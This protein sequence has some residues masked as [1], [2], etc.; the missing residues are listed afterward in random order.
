M[1]QLGIYFVDVL[2]PWGVVGSG[3]MTVAQSITPGVKFSTPPPSCRGD[4]HALLPFTVTGGMPTLYTLDFSDEALAVGF[5]N[6]IDGAISSNQIYIDLPSNV[7]TG[8]YKV[9]VSLTNGNGCESG[10]YD[11]SFSVGEDMV[12][13][14]WDDVLICN[15]QNNEFVSY[16]WYKNGE[17]ITGAQ[18]QYY[19]ELGGFSGDY[20]VVAYRN[21]HSSV[22]SCV[23]S[24]DNK[25]SVAISPN[26]LKRHQT[27]RVVLPFSTDVLFGS[28]LEIVDA[29]GRTLYTND[30][31]EA[32]NG[33]V[34]DYPAGV[35]MVRISMQSGEVITEK[36]VVQ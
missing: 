33:I 13:E 16:Q 23:K 18:S 2:T 3:Q 29:I 28:R 11:L 10:F 25:Q 22:T 31:V 15:D 7:P 14:I 5:Q 8:I 6:V 36:F 12:E 9:R 35:Y 17:R 24:Y 26:P 27:L 4:R 19:S 30:K 32:E 1:A 21:A 34:I 20:Y